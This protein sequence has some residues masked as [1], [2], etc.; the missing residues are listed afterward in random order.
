MN[1]L[2]PQFLYALF[3]L[4]IPVVIH[5]F[6]FQRYKKV[7]FS[8]VSFLKEVKHATQA[9]SNLKHLLIL[10]SRMLAITALVLAFAQ[11]FIPT[12]NTQLSDPLQSSSVF[13]DNSFSAENKIEK[14]VLMDIERQIG[15]E[16]LDVLP[17]SI[18]HQVLTNNFQASQQHLYPTTE[19][20]KKV[21]KVTTNPNSQSLQKIIKRQSTAMDADNYSAYLISDFQKSQYDFSSVSVDSLTNYTLIP[22]EPSNANN[23]SIDSI[24]FL[25]PVHRINQEDQ[26]FFRVTNY[27]NTELKNVDIRLTL[28]KEQRNFMKIDI[29]A[30]SSFDTVFTFHSNST[31]WHSGIISV[32]DY[33]IV[34]DNQFFFNY[35]IRELV[36]VLSINSATSST[37]FKKA[38]RTEPYFDYQ[39]IQETT[40]D[41]RAFQF[42]DLIILN[43]LNGFSSGFKSAILDFVNN[44][45]SLT[46]IPSADANQEELNQLLSN[47]RIQPLGSIQTDTMK[48]NT[49]DL[50]SNLYTGVFSN[51]EAN[52]NLP[53]IFKQ[54]YTKSNANSIPLLGT[55]NNQNILSQWNENKGP[56]YLFTIPMNEAYSN[57]TQHS[58]FL[59]TFFQMGFTSADPATPYQVIG[60][61]ELLPLMNSSV[62]N[63]LIFHVSNTH[64]HVDIIPEI[65]PQNS[66]VMISL[67]GGIE[68][69]ATYQ[70]SQKDSVIGLLS[71]N[72]QRI[73]SNP[74]YHTSNDLLAIIDSL[75]LT[76]FSVFNPTL[77]TFSEDF[78]TREKG[79]ELWRWFVIFTL[80]FL[81]IEIVL[82]RFF[83]PS[84][85]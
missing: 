42:T 76:N 49:I 38:F 58:I 60:V 31:G 51:Q 26:V 19:L 34:F 12:N 63:E 36:H 82:I 15:L 65:I 43:E 30:H 64:L 9:K 5:L 45:G 2:Y 54:F 84:V 61:D 6:N 29:P 23:V 18:N 48:V 68:T 28:N 67:H 75:G 70:V 73:E 77:N 37:S 57:F 66:G 50:K 78:N 7:Y 46:I 81:A 53:T 56:V 33:P 8:N 40:L 4:I 72:Y 85:L 55:P 71:F 41:L 83:K 27:G 20:R 69:A 59:P 16:L 39:E 52:V 3:A 80:L 44:G 1:F 79:I 74:T 13:I 21:Q 10:L 17:K 62:E 47:L 14:S 11:P 22:V 35:H 32:E 24:W 25:N